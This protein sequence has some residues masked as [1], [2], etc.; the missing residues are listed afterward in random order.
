MTGSP[1]SASGWKRERVNDGERDRNLLDPIL[2]LV[3][4]SNRRCNEVRVRLIK[5]ELTD[6]DAA[7]AYATATAPLASAARRIEGI[8]EGGDG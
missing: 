1:R 2:D 6:G 5:G 3:V 4:E 7:S 8:R